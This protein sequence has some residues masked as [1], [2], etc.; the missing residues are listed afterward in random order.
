[1]KI[2]AIPASTTTTHPSLFPPP[3]F[4]PKSL[5][6]NI[7]LQNLHLKYRNKSKTV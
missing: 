2:F 7:N 5:H 6:M 3:Y 4:S 1:M